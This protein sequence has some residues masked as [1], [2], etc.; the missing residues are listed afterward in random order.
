MVQVCPGGIGGQAH[1]CQA[2]ANARN[3]RRERLI[4][5]LE[6]RA[7]S[8][9]NRTG[10]GSFG[11]PDGN[12]AATDLKPWK[13]DFHHGFKSFA[14]VGKSRALVEVAFTDKHRA[15]GISAKPDSVPSCTPLD[16]GS[17][18]LDQ[19]QRGIHHGF[20]V[21]GARG[22]DVIIRVARTCDE[23]L[24]AIENHATTIA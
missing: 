3:A 6:S 4:E 15:T 22:H 18:F 12:G 1:P 20:A 10:K 19:V 7:G 5:M 17:I 11:D 21:Q 2:G 13:Y 14:F 16:A 24:V 23:R 8:V 9:S